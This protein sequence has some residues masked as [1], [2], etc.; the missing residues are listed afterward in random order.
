MRGCEALTTD[1]RTRI[2]WVIAPSRDARKAPVHRVDV[3]VDG[4]AEALRAR[5][6]AATVEL[7]AEGNN[8]RLT[9][10]RDA[11]IGL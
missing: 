3:G 7:A 4:E 2:T 6:I 1:D 5:L 11:R 9:Q 10:T 8:P